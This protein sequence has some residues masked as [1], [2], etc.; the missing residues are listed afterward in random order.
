MSVLQKARFLSLL[1]VPRGPAYFSSVLSEELVLENHWCCV[2]RVHT[3]SFA[4]A[5][6]LPGHLTHKQWSLV[7]HFWVSGSNLDSSSG[8]S[9][10]ILPWNSLCP[11]LM[12][13]Q[14][15]NSSS[16][17]AGLKTIA[18]PHFTLHRKG[19]MNVSLEGWQ[20]QSVWNSSEGKG[21]LGANLHYSQ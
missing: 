16:Q 1:L 13:P 18:H 3:G 2:S 4:Q 21:Y 12:Q 5:L 17:G 7:T 10:G 9:P 15:Q 19:P 11:W 8:L 6:S 20:W 14:G